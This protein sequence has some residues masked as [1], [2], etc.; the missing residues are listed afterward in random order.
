MYRTKKL[1]TEEAMARSKNERGVRQRKE[2][3]NGQTVLVKK[4]LR[5][6][7]GERK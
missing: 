5:R 3:Y 4:V 6:K 1:P 2:R 7:N